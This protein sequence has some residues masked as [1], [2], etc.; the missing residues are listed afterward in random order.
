[1]RSRTLILGLLLLLLPLQ[2]NALSLYESIKKIEESKHG[3][4]SE[5]MVEQFIVHLLGNRGITIETS[6]VD[7]ALEQK[8]QELCKGKE[9]IYSDC[10]Q[11]AVLIKQFSDNEHSIRTLGR[12][13]Q[14]I[15]ASYELPTDERIGKPFAISPRYA[16]VLHMWQA[17]TDALMT[18]V[19]EQ[20]TNARAYPSGI[21]S[22]FV[23]LKSTLEDLQGPKDSIDPLAAAVHRYRYGYKKIRDSGPCTDTSTMTGELTLL[24]RRWCDTEGALHN[25][26]QQL[27]LASS[28]SSSAG[29]KPIT[30][31]PTRIFEDLGVIVWAHDG[32]VGLAWEFPLEPV[33]PTLVDPAYLECIDGGGTR[34]SC[35]AGSGTLFL[36]GEYPP[37]PVDPEP[38][39][40]LCAQ[41][42]GRNGYLCRP[43]QAVVCETATGALLSS[44]SSAGSS[45]SSRDPRALYTVTCKAPSFSGALTTTFSGP[46]MC[47]VGGWANTTP[48]GSSSS[49]SVADT[50][51]RDAIIPN[52]CTNCAVDFFCQDVCDTAEYRPLSLPKNGSGT[53][54]ICLPQPSK[55]AILNYL[56]LH[57][58]AHAGQS[59]NAV[60]PFRKQDAATCCAVEFQAFAVMCNAMAEDGLLDGLEIDGKKRNLSVDDCA[61]ILANLHCPSPPPSSGGSSSSVDNTLCSNPPFDPVLLSEALINAADA[62]KVRLGLPD[63]CEAVINELSP[64]ATLM[65]QS[66]PPVCSPA[67]QT[68]YDSTIGNHLCY[69]GECIE[70]SIEQQRILPGHMALT[71]G[72][73][74]FPWDAC[75][76]P[77]PAIGDTMVLPPLSAPQF[78]PYRP[79]LFVSQM[80]ALVCQLYGQPPGTMPLLCGFDAQRRLQLAQPGFAELAQDIV[81][82]KLEQNDSAESLA[83]LGRSVGARLGTDLYER[84]M[85]SAVRSLSELFGAAGTILKEIGELQFPDTMCSRNNRSCP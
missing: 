74:S 41:P 69:I 9:R 42:L 52:R 66:L 51:A 82:Q 34:T 1:M 58:L 11:L 45:S 26:W 18:P 79:A 22:F 59:C 2:T 64:R 13:L 16:S 39:T 85:Q 8:I 40:G 62:N 61:S 71:T 60:P 17:G 76:L 12:E 67:C 6:D 49:S 27:S 80:D 37:E 78:P 14:I 38:G 50:P 24:G 36:A 75:L 46:D 7:A 29:A 73:Q 15:I 47:G 10:T 30:L 23:I 70:Q 57:E 65:K 25:I 20:V 44:S 83:Q 31:Y 84:Y 48:F 55:P 28:S 21:D 53:I 32:D 72:D 54:A 81:M 77:D 19:V 5:Y 35:G 43:I 68:E 3:N 56:A 63:T 4:K 33:L